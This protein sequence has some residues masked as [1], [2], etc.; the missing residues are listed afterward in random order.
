MHEY[1]FHIYS[2][3]QSIHFIQLKLTGKVVICQRQQINK[4]I[5]IIEKIIEKE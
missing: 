3:I 1:N 5:I 2:S 4:Y